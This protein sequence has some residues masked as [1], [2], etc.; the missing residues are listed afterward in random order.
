MASVYLTRTL[1]TY[2]GMCQR[3]K[4]DP[5]YA[6]IL[7]CNRWLESFN[8]FVEDMGYRPDAMTLDRIDPR[9]DY[10]PSNCRWVSSWVSNELQSKNRLSKNRISIAESTYEINGEVKTLKDWCRQYNIPFS[11]VKTRIRG[12]WT[13]EDALVTPVSTQGNSI[14]KPHKLYDYRGISLSIEKWAAVS[15][16]NV[17]SLRKRVNNNMTILEAITTPIKSNR[18]KFIA[19]TEEQLKLMILDYYDQYGLEL[20]S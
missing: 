8:N 5:D 12:D 20:D 2:R 11:V 9:G 7:I 19:P 1:N 3:V 18:S 17:R 4:K 13:I 16:W 6:N 14:K 10:E 15:G